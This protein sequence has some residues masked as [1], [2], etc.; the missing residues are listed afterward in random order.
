MKILLTGGSGFIGKNILQS[1]LAEKYSI[2]APSHSELDAA[3]SESVDKFFKDKTFDCVIHTATKPSHRNAKDFDKLFYTNLRM[4]ENFERNKDSFG[5]FINLGSGAIYDTSKDISA[6]REIDIFKNIPADEHG[7]CKYCVQ[8][9]IRNLPN[10][11][12]LNIFG[13]FGKYEDY[14]IRFISNAICK[15]IFD[16]PITLRQNRRFSYLW[17][18][19][20]MPILNFFILNNVKESS[21]NI[22]PDNFEQLKSIAEK[23]SAMFGGAPIQ[24][25]AE[26]FGKD[27]YADNSMLKEIFPSVKFTPFDEAAEILVNYYIENK[28]KLS[29]NSLLFDK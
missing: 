23:I 25:G 17:V 18:E 11:L 1:F 24:I 27:Y 9:Q 26:G 2:I 21:V 6:A 3:D 4:F 16:L 10:F 14:S 20:L 8:K 28:N 13:I 7:F 5:K 29:K 15:A 12:D 22:A 19:D